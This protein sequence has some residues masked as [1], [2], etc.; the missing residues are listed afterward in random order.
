MARSARAPRANARAARAEL[1][2]VIGLLDNLVSR[3]TRGLLTTTHHTPHPPSVK[4]IR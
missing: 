1:A 2:R 4:C 3:D